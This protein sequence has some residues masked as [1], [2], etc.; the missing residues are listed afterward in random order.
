MEKTLL[1][2][3]CLLIILSGCKHKTSTNKSDKVAQK[4]WSQSYIER[5]KIITSSSFIALSGALSKSI[6]DGGL[7]N[8]LS[9]CNVNAIPLTDSLSKTYDVTIKRT[10]LNYR[11]ENNKP[12]QKEEQ[13]LRKFESSKNND[14]LMQPIFNVENEIKSFYAPIIVQNAC[15]KCHGAKSGSSIYD[16]INTLYPDDK[17][18]GYLQGDLR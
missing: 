1:L 9:F 3:F 17:A 12:S 2:T 5:G 11:N 13:I 8:A 6:K 16:E 4:E 10:S 14:E 7:Q 15:L 18:T